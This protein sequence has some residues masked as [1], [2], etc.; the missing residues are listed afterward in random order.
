VELT[1]S[2]ALRVC[3]RPRRRYLEESNGMLAAISEVYDA[4]KEEGAKERAA[5][6]WRLESGG[7]A[8]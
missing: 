3:G 8:D 2:R 5:T 7:S 1:P 4:R 6:S